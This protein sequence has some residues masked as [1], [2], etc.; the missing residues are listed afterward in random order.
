MKKW[1]QGD[2]CLVFLTRIDLGKSIGAAIHR[3]EAGWSRNRDRGE[4]KRGPCDSHKTVC[5][6]KKE[7]VNGI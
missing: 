1:L 7:L 6:M 3:K 5:Y 2:I 4:G